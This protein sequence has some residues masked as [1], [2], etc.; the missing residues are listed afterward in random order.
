MLS[1]ATHINT[2]ISQVNCTSSKR[3]GTKTTKIK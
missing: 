2:S 1:V 3:W